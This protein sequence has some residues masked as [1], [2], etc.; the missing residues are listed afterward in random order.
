MEEGEEEIVE[1]TDGRGSG[2]GDHDDRVVPLHSHKLIATLQH[3][4]AGSPDSPQRNPL[5]TRIDTRAG[6][7]AGKPIDKQIAEWADMASCAAKVCGAAWAYQ[8]SIPDESQ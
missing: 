7:G 1:V 4:L 5:L 8:G 6:H 2:A 3:V